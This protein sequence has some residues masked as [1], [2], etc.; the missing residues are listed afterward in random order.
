MSKRIFTQSQIE[1]LLKNK[2]VVRCSEKAI[3]Y[4]AKFKLKAVEQYK[5]QWMGSKEIFE[6]AGFDIGVIGRETPKWCIKRWKKIFKMK[7]KNGLVKIRGKHE[8][9]PKIRDKTDKDKI[10]RLEIEIAYL[11]EENSFLAKLRAKRRE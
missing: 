3:T 9:K 4:D 6:C 1:Q 2:N 11:K 8:G 7:G 5:N 10:N